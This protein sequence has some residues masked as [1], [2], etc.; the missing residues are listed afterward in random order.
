MFFLAWNGLLDQFD[1]LQSCFDFRTF[2]MQYDRACDT[3]GE[4]FLATYQIDA[5]LTKGKEKVKVKFQAHPENS[6]GGVYDA[7]IIRRN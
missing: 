2:A 5:E 3:P 1:Q 4:F 7:R 6:V